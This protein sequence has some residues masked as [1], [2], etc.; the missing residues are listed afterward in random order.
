MLISDRTQSK[1]Q[2]QPCDW[3]PKMQ[4]MVNTSVRGQH[5]LLLFSLLIEVPFFLTWLEK[6]TDRSDSIRERKKHR[7]PL[8]W[9]R[10]VFLVNIE[11]E[12]SVKALG[13]VQNSCGFSFTFS[14][15]WLCHI[16][17]TVIIIVLANERK[18]NTRDMLY[19]NEDLGVLWFLIFTHLC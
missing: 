12:T 5:R 6:K 1:G 17:V 19:D 14:G 2:K 11:I 3:Q 13:Q 18:S 8:L 4:Q 10:N 9:L 15:V 16:I 7:Q